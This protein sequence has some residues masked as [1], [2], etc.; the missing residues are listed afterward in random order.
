MIPLQANYD[1]QPITSNVTFVGLSQNPQNVY[2]NNETAPFEWNSNDKILSVI[3]NQTYS[4]T[5]DIS[6]D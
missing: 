3:V 4:Q 6:W 1:L 2:L 5:Y